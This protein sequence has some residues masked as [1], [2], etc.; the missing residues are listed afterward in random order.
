MWWNKNKTRKSTPLKDHAAS[1]IAAQ[2]V[3]VQTSIA[4]R[5]QRLEQGLNPKQKKIGL[6]LFV[7]CST[8]SLLLILAGTFSD[9]DRPASK[10]QYD[11]S[12]SPAALPPLLLPRKDSI[13]GQH[14]QLP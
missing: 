7:F 9:R 1:W 5:L 11:N 6:M 2:I 8:C 10:K 14:V 3:S 12:M 13:P 4:A